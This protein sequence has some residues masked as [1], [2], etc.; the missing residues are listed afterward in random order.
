MDMAMGTAMTIAMGRTLC[1]GVG[2]CISNGTGDGYDYC[3]G[4]IND[5]GH[6]SDVCIAMIYQ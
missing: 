4:Y 1:D 6:D 3:Y 5:N 2:D